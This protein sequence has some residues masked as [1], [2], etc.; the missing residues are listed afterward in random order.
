MK[1]KKKRSESEKGEDRVI[2]LWIEICPLPASF[3][4]NGVECKAVLGNRR[5][6]DR[7]SDEYA[8][9]DIGLGPCTT[10]E[11]GNEG[12]MFFSHCFPAALFFGDE[13]VSSWLRWA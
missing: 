4:E 10:A 13:A 1:V 7:N 9:I 12:N 2:K 6:C 8:D 3:V 5:L 11:I